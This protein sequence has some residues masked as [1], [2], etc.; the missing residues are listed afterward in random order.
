MNT[1]D[2][3]ADLLARRKRRERFARIACYVL[4]FVILPFLLWSTK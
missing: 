4:V 1:A 2:L 3:W